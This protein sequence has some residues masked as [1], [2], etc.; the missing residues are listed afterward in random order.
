MAKRKDQVM[1]DLIRKIKRIYK[2]C[3]YDSEVKFKQNKQ[4]QLLQLHQNLVTFADN[5]ISQI[6]SEQIAFALG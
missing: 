5:K 1:R 4:N 6:D 3:Y 2:R